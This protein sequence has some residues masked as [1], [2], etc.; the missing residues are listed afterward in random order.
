M[1]F[2]EKYKTGQKHRVFLLPSDFV[3]H[4]L[5]APLGASV[6]PHVQYHHFI[7]IINKMRTISISPARAQTYSAADVVGF[8][9]W[10]IQEG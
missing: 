5:A 1:D 9:R 8:P 7:K 6:T 4:S 3:R 2:L 10:T